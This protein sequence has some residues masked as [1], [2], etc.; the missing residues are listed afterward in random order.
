MNPRP[1][2]FKRTDTLF[3]Y[4]TLFR[5]ARR[6][7]KTRNECPLDGACSADSWPIRP[8]TVSIPTHWQPSQIDQNV[9][10]RH[11]LRLRETPDQDGGF[12]LSETDQQ[13]RFGQLRKFRSNARRQ[14]ARF[15]P[16]SAPVSV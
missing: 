6:I 3:P 11:F 10:V 2:T 12:P 5:S 13:V 16:G 7:F 9:S 8:A 1:P 4:T 14:F 15:Q